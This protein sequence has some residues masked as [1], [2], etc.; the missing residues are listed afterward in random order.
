MEDKVTLLP[1]PFCGAS[2]IFIEYDH[3]DCQPKEPDYMVRC[4]G[5][6]M[7]QLDHIAHKDELARIWNR[8]KAQEALKADSGH[9]S[10]CDCD[11]CQDIDGLNIDGLKNEMKAA[12]VCAHD[13]ELPCLHRR[14]EVQKECVSEPKAESVQS[15]EE[16]AEKLRIIYEVGV[17]EGPV[18]CDQ[19]SCQKAGAIQLIESDRSAQRQAG[20]EEAL[21]EM[22]DNAIRL[23]KHYDDALE[24]IEKH[25]AELVEAASEARPVVAKMAEID[26]SAMWRLT[27][28][29]KALSDLDEA[30]KG[31]AR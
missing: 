28:L 26:F 11:S 12:S 1:C 9:E 23:K 18:Y 29:D 4:E 25:Y 6:E 8:R 19:P 31:D 30:M 16:L 3:G 24:A 7:H 5:E 10:D 27:N 21:A 17:D 14:C 22:A 13:P 2:A 15:A 20:R